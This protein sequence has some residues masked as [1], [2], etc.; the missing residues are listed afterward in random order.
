[1]VA[2]FSILM[3][4]FLGAFLGLDQFATN[5]MNA[6]D[7]QVLGISVLGPEFRAFL[8]LGTVFCQAAII[9]LAM[10]DRVGETIKAAL[11]PMARLIPLGA[12]VAFAWETIS[13]ILL[14]FLPQNIRATFGVAGQADISTAMDNGDFTNGVVFTLI[15]MLLFMVATYTRNK[16]PDSAE[17]KALRKEV[18]RLR[19]AI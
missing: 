17:V 3:L 7:I 12:F 9:F 5:V 15:T 10:I 16:S 8:G 14:G 18:E 13:P 6:S 11:M 1:M 2:I 19:R 4:M